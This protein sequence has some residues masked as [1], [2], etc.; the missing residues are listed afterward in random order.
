MIS[1]K[2]RSLMSPSPLSSSRFTTTGVA[3]TC[4][5]VGK[6]AFTAF[7]I[8]WSRPPHWIS[9]TGGRS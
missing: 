7:F 6:G 5:E 9:L 1:G 3:L 2:S 4:E 8:V